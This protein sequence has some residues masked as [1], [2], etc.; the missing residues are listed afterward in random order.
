MRLTTYFRDLSDFRLTCHKF[1][2]TEGR[3]DDD[4]RDASVETLGKRGMHV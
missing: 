2:L 1:P 4:V 3:W